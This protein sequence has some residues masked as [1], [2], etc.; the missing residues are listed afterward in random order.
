L[1]TLRRKESTSYFG[2]LAGS[3]NPH[4]DNVDMG[5]VLLLILPIGR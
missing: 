5:G 2:R 1:R 3:R 4:D